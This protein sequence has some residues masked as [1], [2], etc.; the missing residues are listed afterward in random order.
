MLGR[1]SNP[2]TDAGS[3]FK[4][5]SACPA[6]RD[7]I[8]QHAADNVAQPAFIMA[9]QINV[10]GAGAFGGTSNNVGRLNTEGL[11]QLA[12]DH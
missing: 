6:G 11:R 9:A 12:D 2:I 4:P 5:G 8:W 10:P 7:T 1:G 3:V